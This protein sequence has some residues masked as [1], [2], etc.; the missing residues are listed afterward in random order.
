MNSLP[1]KNTDP[2]IHILQVVGDPV[3]G[4]RKHVHSLISGLDES[5]F[6]L[7][8]AYSDTATDTRF[9][10]E[11]G[12]LRKRLMGVIPLHIRKKPHYTD[13]TNLWRLMRYVKRAKVDIIHGHGA[14]GGFY[15]RIVGM[16]CHIPA[17]YTPHGGVVHRMFG[18]W[19][20][21]L[22]TL[23]ERCLVGATYCFVFESHYSA[24]NYFSKIGNIKRQWLV[25]YNG[26]EPPFVDSTNMKFNQVKSGP[27]HIGVFGLLRQEKG[28]VHL[29]N[30]VISL[31]KSGQVN[32]HLHIFGDGP[33]RKRLEMKVVNS[34]L[35]NFITFYGDIP[36]PEAWMAKMDIV[37]IPSLFESFGYVGLEAM[38]L[39]KPVIAS[40][41]GGLR[42][43]FEN[44]TAILVPPGDEIALSQAIIDCV[45][46][47]EKTEAMAKKGMV[48][49]TR[50]FSI[51]NM[52]KVI[53]NCYRDAVIM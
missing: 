4:I 5:E 37:V 3:G 53:S 22:Y 7:S 25:N 6:I 17:I 47:P 51:D 29:I 46:N 8:Y 27:T 10:A 19:E 50:F 34:G 28:Q 13:L 44:G 18:F 11:I 35:V 15:A 9:N 31:I 41:V 45:Q 39:C 2:K 24:E 30:A 36:D 43:I 1:K 21:R 52:I 33:D 42:E 12:D 26:I 20:D 16:I 40:E 48:R 38:S 32:I 49:C 14:K 23:I